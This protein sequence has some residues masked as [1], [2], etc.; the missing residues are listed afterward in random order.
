MALPNKSN[1]RE[2]KKMAKATPVEQRRIWKMTAEEKKIVEKATRDGKEFF[3]IGHYIDVFGSLALQMTYAEE[4]A[5]TT[6]TTKPL[7]LL[8]LQTAH[9]LSMIGLFLSVS[10]TLAVLRTE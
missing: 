9:T 6:A 3:Y 2:L 4:E 1:E 8:R 5:N 10:T 7:P